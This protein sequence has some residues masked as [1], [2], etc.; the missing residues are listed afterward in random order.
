MLI[1]IANSIT[2]TRIIG[3]EID[4]NNIKI[5][6]NIITIERI[7]TVLKSVSAIVIKSLV[8]GASPT[9]KESLL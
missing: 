8:N 6:R 5:I 2:L 4:L 7:L 9:T 3:N 1:K